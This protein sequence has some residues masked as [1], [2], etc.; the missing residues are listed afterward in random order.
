M[1]LWIVL[2]GSVT[3]L[4]ALAYTELTLPTQLL[5]SEYALVDGGMPLVLGG[6]LALAAGCL[7][8]AYGLAEREPSRSAAARVLLVAAAGGLILSGLFPTN[9]AGGLA[10][11]VAGEIHRWSAALV[12][13]ALPVA[14]WS[15][16]R[17]RT[18]LPGWH[19]VRFLSIA[20]ALVLTMYL[21][22]HPGSFVSPLINGSAYYGLLERGVVLTE[23]ALLISMGLAAL[24]P[25]ATTTASRDRLAVK[26]LRL[27]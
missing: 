18:T 17:G 16:S 19:P 10:W 14:G 4:G 1:I 2:I 22:S 26:P 3:S 15:L 11:S 9:P 12:F 8:L 7:A 6:M 25:P 20:S 27:M 13:T 21:A 24:R 23:I 5:V